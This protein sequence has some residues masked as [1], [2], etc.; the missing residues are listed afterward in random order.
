MHD[1][2]RRAAAP[3]FLAGTASARRAPLGVL[4]AL[5]LGMLPAF[6]VAQPRYP[7]IVGSGEDR[8]IDYGP[9]PHGNVVGGGHVA[10]SGG[11][12]D[13]RLILLHP[14]S[15]QAPRLGM[16][17]VI[18]AGGEHATTVWVPA[19]TGRLGQ[20]LIGGDGSLPAVAPSDTPTRSASSTVGPRT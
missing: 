5:C 15:G 18:V 19:D 20:A 6:S 8:T 1:T 3:T 13:T 9:G 11:G 4:A 17:P 2:A 7:S 12:E 14:R 10:V 16:V